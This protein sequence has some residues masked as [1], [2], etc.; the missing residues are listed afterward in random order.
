MA[1]TNLESTINNFINNINTI[2]ENL[3]TPINEVNSCIDN[4][5]NY[6]SGTSYNKFI[7]NSEE[8][9]NNLNLIYD[10]V[11]EVANAI[12]V[13]KT[14]IENADNSV[15]NSNQNSV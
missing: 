9:L 12:Y 8:V 4:L 11:S 1:I 5:S 3:T 6:W 13:M 7:A 10:K 14:N 2:S 15:S